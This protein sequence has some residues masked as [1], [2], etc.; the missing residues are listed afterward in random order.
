VYA[1]A[2]ALHQALVMPDDERQERAD[3]LRWIVQR[4]DISAWLCRQIETVVELD[5]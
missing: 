3:R 1:T 2:Q 5:L 4:E